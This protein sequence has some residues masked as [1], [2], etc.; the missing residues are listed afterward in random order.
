MNP[1]SWYHWQGDR[2]ILTVQ[3]QPR[4]KHNEIVGPH[5]DALKV[6]LT[7]PPVDGKANAALCEWIADV[8]AVAKTR[9]TILSG[10]TGRRKRLAIDSPRRLPVGVRSQTG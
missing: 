2:L 9:V 10:L 5:G 7:A 6:R 4:A 3:I 1:A 8:C